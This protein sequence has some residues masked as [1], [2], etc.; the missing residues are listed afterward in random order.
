MVSQEA[1]GSGLG[2]SLVWNDKGLSSDGVF[3]NTKCSDVYARLG[4]LGRLRVTDH[5]GWCVFL[6]LSNRGADFDM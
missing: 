6:A 1:L 3:E 4:L 5:D 2:T